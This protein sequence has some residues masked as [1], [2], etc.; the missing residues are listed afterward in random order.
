MH[1]ILK[2]ALPDA[3]GRSEFIV[4]VIA[5]IRGFSEF[6][7]R[8]ESPDTA[9]YIKRVYL[10]LIDDYFPSASFF[11]T[12]GDGMLMTIPYTY[13]EE[14]LRKATQAAVS[15][16]VR[17][18]KDFPNI[19]EGDPM[20]NF[21]VPSGIGFGLTRGTACCLISGDKVLDYSGQILNLA[22]RLTDLA[23]PSG[24]V[25]DGSFGI[26]LLEEEHQK[27][28][29]PEEVYIRSVAEEEPRSVHILKGV[30]EIPEQAKRP[31]RS[32]QWETV[33]WE[34]TVREWKDRSPIFFV[35]LPRKLK[36]PDGI[37]VYIIHT[38]FKGRRPLS[39]LLTRR[40]F[41][42]SKYVLIGNEPSVRI[43]VD[44][45]LDYLRSERISQDTQVKVS[46]LYVPV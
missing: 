9:M 31:L 2:E 45:M 10:R 16:C 35:P 1:N 15:G 23:R 3:E 32:E 33:E 24:I 6:S 27:L 42:E 20:V 41:D 36:R 30:V 17:C 37:R 44:K 14:S 19:C 22:S 25:L 43:P 28:F 7:T 46:I 34:Q 5:D 4:A 21:A 18:L 38:S 11:K 13:T 40:P 29:E 8:R 26:E 39:D 12:T